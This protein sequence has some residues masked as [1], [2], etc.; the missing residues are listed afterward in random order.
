[1]TC[2][3]RSGRP[4]LR[5]AVVPRSETARLIDLVK[6]RGIVPGSLRSSQCIVSPW[7]PLPSSHSDGE[8][9]TIAWPLCMIT[10]Q[11]ATH[12][13]R[14]RNLSGPHKGQRETRLVPRRQWRSSAKQACCAARRCDDTESESD[15]VAGVEVANKSRGQL[16]ELCGGRKAMNEEMA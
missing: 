3:R 12:T 11:V 6:F 5:I 8:N 10:H 2:S 15:R 7:S 4:A 16:A 1:M 13:L 9:S 14:R